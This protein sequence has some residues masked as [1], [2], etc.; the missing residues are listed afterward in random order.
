MDNRSIYFYA[1]W[2]WQPVENM[3]DGCQK[4]SI[5][6]ADGSVKEVCSCDYWWAVSSGKPWAEEIESFKYD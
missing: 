6:L 2:E 5:R 1:P 4:V 3:P